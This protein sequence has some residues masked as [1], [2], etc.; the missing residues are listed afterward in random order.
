MADSQKYPVRDPNTDLTAGNGAD[1]VFIC[2]NTHPFDY[3]TLTGEHKGKMGY[4]YVL[5]TKTGNNGV[6]TSITVNGVVGDVA[7][8]S[9]ATGWPSGTGDALEIEAMTVAAGTYAFIYLKQTPEK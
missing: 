3:T 5:R 2:S 1:G 7:S 6:I 9:D 8:L 4:A